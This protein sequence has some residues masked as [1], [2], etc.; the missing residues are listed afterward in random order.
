MTT[1]EPVAPGTATPTAA[2][3]EDS[4]TGHDE[5]AAARPSRPLEVTFALIALAVSGTYL[6]LATQI[7]LRQAAAPGQIDARFW[8]TVLGV[9]AVA[10]A[11]VLLAIALTRPPLSRDD[12]EAIQPNGLARVAAT[13][14]LTLLYVGAWT[15]SSVVLLGYRIELFPV[16]T[17]LFLLALMLVYGQRKWLGLVLYP[18]LVT[19]FIYVLFGMLLRVPL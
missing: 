15:V 19:A 5:H 7:P 3:A 14:A 2:I 18:V 4:G 13:V 11:V 9:S 16:V 8:P 1:P 12:I 10:V 17:A 6:A